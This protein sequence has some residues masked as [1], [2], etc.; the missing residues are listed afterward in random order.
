MPHIDTHLQDIEHV[1]FPRVVWRTHRELDKV[2]NQIDN[3]SKKYLSRNAY[4]Y[5][6]ARAFLYEVLIKGL[7]KG[8]SPSG[9]FTEIFERLLPA[10]GHGLRELC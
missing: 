4:I 8:I 9:A 3:L 7:R 2:A 6:Y 5:R 1:V 10:S